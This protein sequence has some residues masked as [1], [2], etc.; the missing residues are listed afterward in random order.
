M[1]NG[2]LEPGDKLLIVFGSKGSLSSMLWFNRA[3]LMDELK[4]VL[5]IRGRPISP[6]DSIQIP[7]LQVTSKNGRK[8]VFSMKDFTKTGS[9]LIHNLYVLREEQDLKKFK[10]EPLKK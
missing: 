6:K 8:E 7:Y 5:S 9:W 4:G 3:Q 2:R 10:P 1:K